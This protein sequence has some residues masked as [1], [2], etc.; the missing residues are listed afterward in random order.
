MIK[1]RQGV[2]PA[3]TSA[4][5]TALLDHLYEFIANWQGIRVLP[6]PPHERGIRQPLEQ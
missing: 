4:L 6:V 5:V 3:E 2:R 1:A